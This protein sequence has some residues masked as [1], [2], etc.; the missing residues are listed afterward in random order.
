MGA[1]DGDGLSDFA[2]AI[3]QAG[4]P[5]D[6]VMHGLRK[7]ATETLAEL[8]C[9]SLVIASMTG[10]RSLKEIE[11]YTREA[12]QKRMRQRRSIGWNGTETEP[13]L[14]NVPDP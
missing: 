12:D 3:E 13:R 9:S 10:H 1:F 7:T 14:A 2:S 4:L 8:D 11:R 6:C 5:D